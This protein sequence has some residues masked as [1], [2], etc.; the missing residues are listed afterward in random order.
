MKFQ[1]WEIPAG[2]RLQIR[3]FQTSYPI[4]RSKPQTLVAM[5]AV[6]AHHNEKIFPDSHAFIPE[7]WSDQPGGG[8]SLEKYLVSSAA[9]R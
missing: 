3:P 5:T 6:I 8:R 4:T 2:I 1:E 7:R 9:K